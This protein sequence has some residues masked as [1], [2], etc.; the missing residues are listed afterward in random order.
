MGIFSGKQGGE[1]CEVT[2]E[3]G[4]THHCQIFEADKQGKM[5]T[6][7]DFIV[8][9]SKT[10]NCEPVFQGSYDILEKDNARVKAIVEQRVRACRK[11][12]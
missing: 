10:N 8:N 9:V 2:D 11:G 7:T 4:E 5:A 3:T 1:R 6:G 12:L